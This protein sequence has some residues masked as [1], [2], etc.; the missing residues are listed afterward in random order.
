M[1]WAGTLPPKI[2]VKERFEDKV[3]P[4]TETGCH[5][6]TAGVDTSG[7][8]MISIKGRSVKASRV[9]YEMYVGEIPKGYGYHGTCVLHKCDNR[10]CVNPDHLFLGSQKDN[11]LDMVKKNR[12]ATGPR[13]AK[14]NPTIY[15]FSHHNGDKFVGTMC[16]F[17]KK[18][19]LSRTGVLHL[20]AGGKN[21]K[22]NKNG[23]SAVCK[24]KGWKVCPEREVSP[25]KNNW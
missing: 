20:I 12:Q 9:S 6:W 18:Y 14:F 15:S 17:Y 2:T 13:N 16:D 11:V 10:L 5:I 3:M 21:D 8:A 19:N 24:Y 22:R 7:Y 4:I 25:R 1:R 23:W